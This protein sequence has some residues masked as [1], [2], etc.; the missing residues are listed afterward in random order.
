MKI[1]TKLGI[2]SVL[3]ALSAS[4]VCGR[5]SGAPASTPTTSPEEY[6][7]EASLHFQPAFALAKTKNFA[8]ETLDEHRARRAEI[9]G[10][11]WRAVN[12]PATPALFLGPRAKIDAAL[13]VL[14]VWKEESHFDARVDKHHCVDLPKGSCD[15]GM[16]FCM[17]Q[18]HPKD[19][20]QLG[21]TGPELL[22]DRTKCARATITR[23]VM[24]RA[25]A[26][27]DAPH[28]ADRYC[29]Y[30]VGH[31][32]TPCPLMRLRYSYGAAWRASHP[33]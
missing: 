12:D 31:Y 21:Y 6:L 16:A 15:G 11:V 24:A 28:P 22:A 7:L 23:L 29:G 13:F 32:Q 4:F 25:G 18:V 1:L 14:G 3:L 8:G 20:P 2:G 30:A 33:F 26:P 27:K 19:L 17:G 9:V 10:D 5:A